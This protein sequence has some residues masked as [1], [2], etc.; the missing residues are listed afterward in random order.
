MEKLSGDAV[1]R[2]VIRMKREQ[3]FSSTI[4]SLDKEEDSATTGAYIDVSDLGALASD[5]V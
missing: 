4:F 3:N 5:D 1:C 2:Y